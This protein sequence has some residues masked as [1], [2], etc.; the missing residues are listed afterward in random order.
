MAEARAPLATL[1]IAACACTMRAI[2]IFFLDFSRP[3]R[4]RPTKPVRT[5][6]HRRPA[7]LQTLGL[8]EPGSALQRQVIRPPPCGESSEHCQVG[9][10]AFFCTRMFHA[11]LPTLIASAA[12]SPLWN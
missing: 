3:R 6:L 10:A 8:C 7:A 12:R 2:A 11:G 9:P 5:G 1:L 4:T